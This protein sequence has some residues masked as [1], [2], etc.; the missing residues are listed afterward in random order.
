MAWIPSSLIPLRHQIW[1]HPWMS[2]MPLH[3][4]SLLSV[5]AQLVLFLTLL[6]HSLL[7]ALSLINWGAWLGALLA[8]V[9]LATKMSASGLICY[10]SGH[11]AAY[12]FWS[13]TLP[14]NITLTPANRKADHCLSEFQ[15]GIDAAAHATLDT[16]QFLPQNC[17]C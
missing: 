9:T 12:G 6:N 15:T 1:T 13:S 8:P 2:L 14:D 10:F 16:E 17:P 5:T 4:Q 11:P 3:L 7:L